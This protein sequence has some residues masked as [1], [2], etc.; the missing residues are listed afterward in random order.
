VYN[1]FVEVWVSRHGWPSRRGISVSGIVNDE[2]L[3]EARRWHSRLGHQGIH[4]EVAILGKVGTRYPSKVYKLVHQE[5]PYCQRL[6]GRPSPVDR[7]PPVSPSSVM[8]NEEVSV[9]LM[10]L[11]KRGHQVLVC[12]CSQSRYVEL[13]VVS[14][15]KASIVYNAFVEVW[16]SHHGWPSRRFRYDGGTE[17]VSLVDECRRRGIGLAPSPP[18]SPWSNGRNERSHPSIRSMVKALVR[19]GKLPSTLPVVKNIIEGH[20]NQVL[21]STPKRVLGGNAPIEFTGTGISIPVWYPGQKV[22]YLSA[23]QG[24]FHRKS[25]DPWVP[26]ICLGVGK[27]GD[28]SLLVGNQGKIVR[29]HPSRLSRWVDGSRVYRDVSIDEHDVRDADVGESVDLESSDDRDDVPLSRLSGDDV[30]PVGVHEPP[31]DPGLPLSDAPV[32]YDVPPVGVHEPPPDPGLPLSD[33]PVRSDGDV[34]LCELVSPSGATMEVNMGQQGIGTCLVL[35]GGT[36][37]DVSVLR[38][39]FSRVVSVDMTDQ[40]AIE[41][42]KVNGSAAVPD[43]IADILTW[44]FSEWYCEWVSGGNPPVCAVFATPPCNCFTAMRDMMGRVPVTDSDWQEACEIVRR[45]REI[46]QFLD[47]WCQSRYGFECVL[48]M[49][50]PTSGKIVSSGWCEGLECTVSSWCKMG[51]DCMKNTSIF[52]SK[53]IK[54]HLPP[55]C[56]DESP[57][58]IRLA[59]RKHRYVPSMPRLETFCLPAMFPTQFAI[60]SRRYLREFTKVHDEWDWEP[61]VAW[62][63]VSP[64]VDASEYEPQLLAYQVAMGAVVQASELSERVK[65]ESELVEVNGWY[66]KDVYQWVPE[67]VG[68]KMISEGR[69]FLVQYRWVFTQSDEVDSS[70]TSRLVTKARCVLKGFQDKRGVTGESPTVDKVT[71]RAFYF[72]S[73]CNDDELVFADVRKAF[74]NADAADGIRLMIRPPVEGMK[75]MPRCDYAKGPG[76]LIL[77]KAV[78]GSIDAGRLWNECL[79]KAFL[80]N[81]WKRSRLDP[82]L[83]VKCDESG[84]VSTSVVH[85]DDIAASGRAIS[86]EVRSLGYQFREVKPVGELGSPMLGVE[87]FKF[88]SCIVLSME[89]YIVAKLVKSTRK[90]CPVSPLPVILPD[91]NDESE[92]IKD[93]I[94]FQKPLG[95]LMWIA[96]SE[97]F[98]ILYAVNWLSR[99][100][101]APRASHMRV[102]D[103]LLAYVH[104]TKHLKLLLDCG[105]N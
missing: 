5:C 52:H 66:D 54:L 25:E 27:F 70:S 22:R 7:R 12:Q 48:G 104:G 96:T 34:R 103:H 21:N 1:A 59:G 94:V 47:E 77:V 6:K 88:D 76:F 32:H 87:V 97:R 58:P 19:E 105:S 92:L 49:E 65:Y 42:G 16:V 99:Y 14:C 26:A 100:T 90:S 61:S 41:C 86:S 68:L 67:E 29:V 23:P 50:N 4:S 73:L 20:V 71:L 37:R 43:V 98:D 89:K 75:G 82:C 84:H 63:T 8:F 55:P 30:P 69:A 31:P 3:A 2:V 39:Y 35:C 62:Y 11:G 44:D 51:S 78:Y 33:A 45:V 83:Y 28:V 13:K 60:A 64:Q 10:P 79:N 80:M 74:L 81:R 85:V 53:C 101:S 9:D 56:C 95:Q 15:K 57:C 72:H 17:F 18:Y 46:H 40:W 102:L 36:G 38:R 91:G 24:T 93:V